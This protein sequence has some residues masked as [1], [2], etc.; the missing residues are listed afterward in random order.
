MVYHVYIIVSFRVY[1]VYKLMDC[2]V[3]I[4]LFFCAQGCAAGGGRLDE[5]CQPGVWAR[6]YNYQP[7]L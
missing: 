2:D 7:R 4:I 3:Y 6:I 1:Y 5:D